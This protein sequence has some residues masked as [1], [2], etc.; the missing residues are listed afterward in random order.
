[1]NH[2]MKNRRFALGLGL[3]V[4]SAL[5][6]ATGAARAAV[7]AGYAGTPHGGSP[8]AIPG[9]VNLIDYDEGGRGVGFN[10]VHFNGDVGCAGYDYRMD[11]PVATLCKTSAT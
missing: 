3:A 5:A 7:P 10:T 1:M 9:R 6:L 4:A 2:L 8:H 11:K